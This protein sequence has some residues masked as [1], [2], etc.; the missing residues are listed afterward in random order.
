MNFIV[1]YLC[2]LQGYCNFLPEEKLLEAVQIGQVVSL[3]KCV[4]YHFS[5]ISVE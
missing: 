4:A 5:H 2:F 3:I 1:H